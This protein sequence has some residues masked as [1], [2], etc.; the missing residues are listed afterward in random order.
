MTGVDSSWNVN[1]ALIFTPVPINQRWHLSDCLNKVA[2]VCR[3]KDTCITPSGVFMYSQYPEV[4]IESYDE[5][6]WWLSNAQEEEEVVSHRCF[7]I[8]DGL[9]SLEH[10]ETFLVP[11]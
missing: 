9:A 1:I 10:D 8:G 6:V 4:S 7:G 2:T 3:H 5:A 11:S